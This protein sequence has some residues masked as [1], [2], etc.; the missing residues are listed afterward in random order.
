MF[1]G[2]EQTWVTQAT[3][4]HN[5][6]IVWRFRLTIYCAYSIHVTHFADTL[7]NFVN[8]T[9]RPCRVPVRASRF[10]VFPHQTNSPSHQHLPIIIGIQSPL[11]PN[12]TSCAILYI[13]VFSTILMLVT[14]KVGTTFRTADLTGIDY[15]CFSKPEQ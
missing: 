9:F 2:W 8:I 12:S 5:I 1:L 4:A 7:A 11:L 3:Q 6:S 10:V 15:S 13:L 14:A